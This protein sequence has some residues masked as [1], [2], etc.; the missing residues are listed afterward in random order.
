MKFDDAV[1]AGAMALF[2]EK[3]DED[4]RVLRNRRLLDRTLRRY[5]RQPR[6]R[7][8]P[9]QDRERGRR[10]GGRTPHRGRHRQ[11][12]FDYVL[13]TEHRLRDVAASCA[14]RATTSRR[15]CASCSSAA[16]AREGSAQL[17]DKLA[18]GQGPRCRAEAVT[19]GGLKVVA[20]II[21]GADAAAL[22]NAVDQL[23]S[24]LGSAVIVL[25]PPMPTAS[26]PDRR[27]HRRY[28]TG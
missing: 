25:V 4:V 20:T 21:E 10:R 17:K 19:V 22:R 1:A 18:S 13:Q 8:R 15:R 7:H 23:K 28:D 6:R 16:A 3:Y 12:A 9:V 26:D 2:G 27:S 14:A 5:A 11:G 24:R